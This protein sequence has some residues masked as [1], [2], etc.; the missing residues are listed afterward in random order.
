MLDRSNGYEALASEIIAGRHRSLIGVETV[1]SWAS[2][3]PH[4]A[5][6]LDLGCGHG[7]PVSEALM[8]DGFVV[9]GIDASPSLIAEYRARFPE[10]PA[11]CEAVE[12]S[13]FFG[14]RFDGIIAIG[15]IFLLSPDAQRELLSRIPSAL[16]PGAKFLFSAPKERA[17]WADMLTRRES[18]S[19]GDDEYQTLLKVAGLRV[20][21]EYV[22][23]GENHYF[24]C[25]EMTGVW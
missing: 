10:A 15:L 20:E 21:D 1:R 23:E 25:E 2:R 12:D 17:S 24:A 6:I 5:S 8:T 13:T 22:D 3:L 7:V 4:G 19:L 18:F 9:F 14:R 16:K 11:A